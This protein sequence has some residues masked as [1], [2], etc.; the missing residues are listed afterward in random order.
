[1]TGVSEIFTA[2]CYCDYYILLRL[3]FNL[4][5]NKY[6]FGIQITR[7]SSIW[8]RNVSGRL[9]VEPMPCQAQNVVV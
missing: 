2:V 1:M 3:F 9:L 8:P 5:D 4:Y 7:I 6:P